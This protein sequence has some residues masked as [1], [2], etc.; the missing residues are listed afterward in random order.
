MG[1]VILMGA[2][3]N[4]HWIFYHGAHSLWVYLQQV[5]DI[6][7]TDVCSSVAKDEPVL[8]TKL[9]TKLVARV[10]SAPNEQKL[11]LKFNNNVIFIVNS[12]NSVFEVLKEGV[13][14]D[15]EKILA[16]YEFKLDAF[17]NLYLFDSSTGSPVS[18]H[19]ITAKSV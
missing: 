11:P 17:H 6:D 15:G 13:E 10:V 5:F 7:I 8:A 12:I 4:L 14:R 18:E 9:G 3:D 16:K 19:L 1:I 2:E